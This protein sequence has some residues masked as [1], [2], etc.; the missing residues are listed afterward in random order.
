MSAII[1]LLITFIDIFSS[2]IVYALIAHVL[3]SWFATGRTEFGVLLDRIVRPILRPFRW[4]RIGMM[5]LSIIVAIL[6]I[7]GLGFIVKRGLLML[8]G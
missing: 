8:V 5:D 7:D 6:V 2:L 4:A 1:N 3:L